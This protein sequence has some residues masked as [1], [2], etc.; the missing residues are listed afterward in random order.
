MF[1]DF[2][3][4]ERS[5]RTLRFVYPVAVLLFVAACGGSYS[6][7]TNPTPSPNPSP[8]SGNAVSIPSGA[9]NLG[10]A[11]YK[12]NPITVAVGTT[13]TWTNSDS[14]AHTVTSDGGLFNS[15]SMAPG[16]T[17]SYMFPVAGSYPYHCTLHPG[18]VGTVV[19]Q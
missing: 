12:P 19:V 6:S 18:M 7:P 8:T 4:M 11:G 5:M 13:V 2:V 15:N 17:F 1:H 10:N 3:S 9:E 16:G 14:T